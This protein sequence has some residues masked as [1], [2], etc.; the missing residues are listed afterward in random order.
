MILSSTLSMIFP[1]KLCLQCSKR[2]EFL[3]PDFESK[4]KCV[5]TRCPYAHRKKTIIRPR[6]LTPTNNIPCLSSRKEV[7]SKLEASLQSESTSRYFGNDKR[8][9][10]PYKSSALTAEETAASTTE[11]SDSTLM[12]TDETYNDNLTLIP[13]RPRLGSL[14]SFIPIDR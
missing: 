13:Q 2:H 9:S 1:F 6:K 3:C 5:Q 4:G 8:D 12:D 7:P 10:I 11:S 14:P